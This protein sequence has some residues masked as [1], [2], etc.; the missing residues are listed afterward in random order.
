MPVGGDVSKTVE[1]INRLKSEA[2]GEDIDPRR[3]KATE[4]LIGMVRQLQQRERIASPEDKQHEKFGETLGEGILSKA[5]TKEEVLDCF[6]YEATNLLATNDTASTIIT[7]MLQ[8]LKNKIDFEEAQ[9]ILALVNSVV[10]DEKGI[11][12]LIALAPRQ[13]ILAFEVIDQIAKIHP[14]R[15]KEI[16]SRIEAGPWKEGKRF[17]A[18]R[19]IT[20]NL[21]EIV[22][23]SGWI[24]VLQRGGGIQAFLADAP[25]NPKIALKALEYIKTHSPK[26]YRTLESEAKGL[27]EFVKILELS[28][29]FQEGRIDAQAT[30]D[31]KALASAGR[32]KD[33]ATFLRDSVR[34]LM[35]AMLTYCEA[36]RKKSPER[37]S[38]ECV[39]KN[40]EAIVST[41]QLVEEVIGKEE[42]LDMS[43]AHQEVQRWWLKSL[44]I[45]QPKKGREESFD[46]SEL[47]EL[48]EQKMQAEIQEAQHNLGEDEQK[49]I[50]D[51]FPFFRLPKE[52]SS[53]LGRGDAVYTDV[54]G[55]ETKFSTLRGQSNS[56]AACR[57]AQAIFDA[58]PKEM[59]ENPS[60]LKTAIGRLFLA[61]SQGFAPGG[62]AIAYI[63]CLSPMFGGPA[64]SFSG[65]L[66]TM[67]FS[68]DPEKGLLIATCMV[69]GTLIDMSNSKESTAC[70][71]F[72]KIE[73][74]VGSSII[75]MT[76]QTLK[77]QPREEVQ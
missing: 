46:I 20:Q 64:V 69:H 8:A 57:F 18:I 21:N 56:L 28:N 52:A 39:Y 70:R 16:R 25:K 11:D 68:I 72:N 61:A 5:K 55:T 75:H 35:N 37:P 17:F 71:F 32:L 13:R 10:K 45:F 34:Q 23:I 30:A 33:S 48:S 29:R 63:A 54:T 62:T 59:K 31:V 47:P 2:L 41:F 53:D 38:M 66:E 42:T 36:E 43:K 9:K 77:D 22:A 4:K 60:A 3:R 40:G 12:T 14:E 58:C 44:E 26:T 7:S 76:V 49:L 6:V 1:K 15:L 27:E 73:I 51:W 24:D 74:P 19:E 67:N 50:A 65:G